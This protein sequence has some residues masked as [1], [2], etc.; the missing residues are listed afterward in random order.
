MAG[1][2]KHRVARLEARGDA[3]PAMFAVQFASSDEIE[4]CGTGERMPRELFYRRNPDG[5]I[6]LRLAEE[7]WAVL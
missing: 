5:R 2:L 7:L 1:S 3:R 4:I 6:I